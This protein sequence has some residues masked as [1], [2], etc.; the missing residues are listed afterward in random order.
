MNGALRTERLPLFTEPAL[1]PFRAIAVAARPGLRAVLVTAL[2]PG[3]RILDG[4]ELEKF[5][6]VGPLFLQR[7]G[8]EAGLDPFDPAVGKLARVRHVVQILVAGDRAGPQR[9]IVNRAPQR[10]PLAVLQSRRYKVRIGIWNL[11]FGM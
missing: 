1:E 5:L 4:V 7:C 11:G 2:A 8:T 6:P 10:A 3:V 9:S